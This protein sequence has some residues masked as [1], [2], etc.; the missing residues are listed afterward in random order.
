MFPL[1]GCEEIFSV[2]PL[3]PKSGGGEE[4]GPKSVSY[5]THSVPQRGI[6]DREGQEEREEDEILPADM[7]LEVSERLDLEV[8]ERLDLKVSEHLD[9]EVSERMD[10]EVSEHLD[11]E[12]SERL[13]GKL[14]QHTRKSF[15]FVSMK[16]CSLKK[17]MI[18]LT[19]KFDDYDFE[20]NE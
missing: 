4:T 12:V 11:L 2:E 1:Q 18:S 10:L 17:T 3:A 7:D 14:T 5:V 20:K 16:F 9:L 6:R 15:I 13:E 19:P 8:S